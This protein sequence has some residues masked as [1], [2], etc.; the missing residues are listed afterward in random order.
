MLY[1][2]PCTRFKYEVLPSTRLSTAGYAEKAA[3]STYK[4]TQHN[5]HGVVLVVLLYYHTAQYY[6]VL[7]YTVEIREQLLYMY[8]TRLH[9]CIHRWDSVI[10]PGGFTSLLV[11]FRYPSPFFSHAL[12]CVSTAFVRVRLLTQPAAASRSEPC[13]KLLGSTTKDARTEAFSSLFTTKHGAAQSPSITG[14]VAK[15]L[16]I[17]GTMLTLVVARNRKR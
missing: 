7:P 10:G 4:C 14:A 6:C 2:E 15:Q 9:K 1:C 3:L 17:A 11:S 13:C 8:D 5:R 12:L 16:W